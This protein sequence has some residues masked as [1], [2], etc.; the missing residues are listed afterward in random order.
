MKI[1]EYSNNSPTMLIG[2]DLLPEFYQ[3]VDYLKI[4]N[5][6][7]AQ[8]NFIEPGSYA[9]PHRDYEVRDNG[10]PEDADG[11]CQVYIP[12]V[13]D[14][15]NYLKIGG[16]GVFEIGT[17]SLVINNNYYTHAVVNASQ[18]TRSVLVIRC[19]FNKNWHLVAS[20]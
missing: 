5:I 2:P 4:Q 12:L 7:S 9:P 8:I 14:A 13:S 15:N 20:S 10:Y 6:Y 19:N 11:C 3:L 18:N 16:V 17:K 1:I